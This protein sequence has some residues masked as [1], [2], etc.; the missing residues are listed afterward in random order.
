MKRTRIT[1]ADL[2]ACDN[3]AL[4]AWKAARGKRQ[5]PEV[6][7]FLDHFDASIA[8]LAAD[9]L[10]GAAPRGEYRSFLIHDPKKRLI[11]AACFTDRVLQHAILNL[12]EAVFERSLVPTT[13]ACRSAR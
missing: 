12:S 6:R 2:A 8:G 11:H 10:S 5:R 9:V 3:L 4:A 7:R 13:Y 1:L